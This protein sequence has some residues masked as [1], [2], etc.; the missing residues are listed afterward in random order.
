[1]IRSGRKVTAAVGLVTLVTVA[2]LLHD[3]LTA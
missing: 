1:M 3:D 2:R